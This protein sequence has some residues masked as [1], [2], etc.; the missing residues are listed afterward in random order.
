MK[1]AMVRLRNFRRLEDVEIDFEDEETVLVGP[2]NSGKTSATG[3]FRLFLKNS[4]FTVHDFC[5]SNIE[6]LNELGAKEDVDDEMVPS[7]EMDLWFSIGP[8][9]EWGRVALLLPGKLTEVDEI[10]VR[11]KWGVKDAAKLKSDYLSAFPPS[12]DGRPTKDMTHYLSLEGN[13]K[14]H[15]GLSYFTLDGREDDAEAKPVKPEEGKKTLASLI[16]VDSVD[17][18]RGPV[19]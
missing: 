1:L 7:I 16:R 4:A 2:N 5:A 12:N 17:A 8:D 18:Q 13:L 15:F 11:I 9:S 10:G 14:R 19:S 6:A 3:A